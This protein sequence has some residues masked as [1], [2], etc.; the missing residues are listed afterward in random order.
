MVLGKHWEFIDLN[1]SSNEVPLQYTYLLIFTIYIKYIF[2][3][4]LYVSVS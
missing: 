2:Y 3:L 4:K 1:V